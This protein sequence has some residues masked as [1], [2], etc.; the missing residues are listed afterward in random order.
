M[1]SWLDL[2]YNQAISD[3][4]NELLPIFNKTSSKF[5]RATIPTGDWSNQVIRH[6]K[7]GNKKHSEDMR[8]QVSSN[9]GWGEG[10]VCDVVSS[11]P[12]FYYD[13]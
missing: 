7:N 4:A 12:I 6:R 3:E 9:W 8:V 10:A 11:R 5:Y 1:F 2:F 13:G